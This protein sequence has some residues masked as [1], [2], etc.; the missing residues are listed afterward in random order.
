[1]KWAIAQ[2]TWERQKEKVVANF[3]K[4]EAAWNLAEVKAAVRKANVKGGKGDHVPPD[5]SGIG[6]KVG[7]KGNGGTTPGPWNSQK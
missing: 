6:G 4:A 5:N 1:M 2:A 3:T 7:G